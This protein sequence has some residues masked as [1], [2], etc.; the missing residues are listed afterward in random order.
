MKVEFNSQSGLAFARLLATLL[1]SVF[2]TFGWTFDA[3]LVFN[4]LLSAIAV[5]LFVYSWWKN[6]NITEAAQEAQKV[7]DQIKVAEKDQTDVENAAIEAAKEAED[8]G[9]SVNT[10]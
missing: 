9:E 6:N 2:A 1:V 8:A 5:A 7:L 3:D 10:L 4:L